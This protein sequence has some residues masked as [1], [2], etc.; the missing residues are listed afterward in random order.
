ML[1]IVTFFFSAKWKRQ[2]S[3]R[4]LLYRQ[5]PRLFQPVLKGKNGLIVGATHKL[6]M[7]GQVTQMTPAVFEIHHQNTQNT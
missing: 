3:T 2:T 7:P 1:N 5:S 6:F 4:S